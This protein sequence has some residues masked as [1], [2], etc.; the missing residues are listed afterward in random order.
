MDE[1]L[2]DYLHEVATSPEKRDQQ[3]LNFIG[4][5]R[6]IHDDVFENGINNFNTTLFMVLLSYF[7]RISYLDK[8]RMSY[9][10]YGRYA[11]FLKMSPKREADWL[12]NAKKEEEE[13]HKGAKGASQVLLKV[14]DS[15]Q[16]PTFRVFLIL[17]TVCVFK[18]EGTLT[19]KQK[20]FLDY[21][22]QLL[23]IQG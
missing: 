5:V 18:D 13:D 23:R 15:I 4:E 20:E 22:F 17:L 8:T 6:T 16:E 19:K 14:A 21:F 2:E 7:E 9:E 3:A 1:E 10:T 11:T 12:A